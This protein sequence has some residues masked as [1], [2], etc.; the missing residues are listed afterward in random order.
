MNQIEWMDS[1]IQKKVS[2]NW[3]ESMCMIQVL[4][5]QENK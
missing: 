4:I 2:R 1:T 3:E 5:Y